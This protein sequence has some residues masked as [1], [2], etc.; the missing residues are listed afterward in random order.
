M[1]YVYK[2]GV[3]H[4]TG[5]TCCGDGRLSPIEWAQSFYLYLKVVTHTSRARSPVLKDSSICSE[6]QPTNR[7]CLSISM[8][9][10]RFKPYFQTFCLESWGGCMP[11]ALLPFFGHAM[12]KHQVT[13]WGQLGHVWRTQ[14]TT[15]C[16][17][18][19]QHADANQGFMVQ[20]EGSKCQRGQKDRG[21]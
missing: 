13:Q 11:L 6:S 5:I 20:P 12:H 7:R 2:V 18:S 16:T 8:F 19:R 21:V 17:S 9:D 15:T 10:F 1:L 3:P 14:G 4:P